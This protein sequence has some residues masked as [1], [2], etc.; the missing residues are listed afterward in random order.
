MGWHCSGK[1]NFGRDTSY[2][3]AMWEYFYFSY[4]GDDKV[5]LNSDLDSKK[6]GVDLYFLFSKT[7]TEEKYTAS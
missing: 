3:R 1:F 7:L 5:D 4:S 2:N 6:Q